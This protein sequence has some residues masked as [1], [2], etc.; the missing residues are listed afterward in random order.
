MSDAAP[1][2][3]WCAPPPTRARWPR[4]AASSGRAS[5]CCR[6]PTA[7]GDVVEDAGSLRRQRPTQG[8]R[9]RPRRRR[10]RR[11]PTTPASRST[12]SAA[13]PA[14]TR[15]RS[16]ARAPPTRRTGRSC[17]PCSATDPTGAPASAPSRWWCGPTAGSCYAEGTCTGEIAR[18]PTRHARLR[19]RQRVRA[20]RRRRAHVRRDVG[21]REG[22][23]SHRGR[24]FSALR[25]ARVAGRSR[26]LADAHEAVTPVITTWSSSAPARATRSP[27]RSSTTS[28]S[29]SSKAARSAAPASTS[30]ASRPRC[31]CTPPTSPTGAAE[32]GALGVDMHARARA[33]AGDP[34]PHLRAHRP[35][36]RGGRAYREGPRTPTSPC[37]RDGPSSSATRRSTS[38]CTTARRP[39]SPASGSCSPPAAGRSCPTSPASHSGLASTRPTRSCASRRCRRRC[40]SSAAASS[41]PSSPTCSGR[42]ASR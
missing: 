21:R 14:S 33:L 40:S 11:S 9:R 10:A 23:I 36:L 25:R 42:S 27:G 12:R 39:P 37:T 8:G 41:P 28:T 32:G 2:S 6:D 30:A 24:A 22:R 4:S 38:P 3:R 5:S 26:A 16:P 1:L 17:S 13:H 34:R 19:L 15:P 18:R 31:T 35:D 29:P 20:R 7:C